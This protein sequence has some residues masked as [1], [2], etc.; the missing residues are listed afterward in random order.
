MTMT[1]Y[2]DDPAILALYARLGD[3]EAISERGE[4]GATPF[5]SPREAIYAKSYLHPKIIEG[6]AC[7][8]GGYAAAERVRAVLLPS[9]TQGMVTCREGESPAVALAEAGFDELALETE[10]LVTALLVSGSG[11]R[12]LTHRDY[13]GSV[14]GLGLERDVVGDILVIDPHSAYLICKG[15]IVPFLLESLT[16]VGNDPVKVKVLPPRTPLAVEKKTQP[17]RD[18]VASPRLDCVVAALCNLSR[19]KAQNVIKSGLAEVNY[20]VAESCDLHL[21][22]PCVLSVRGVG[23]FSV[24][25]FDGETRKGRL[26]LVAEKYV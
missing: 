14:L 4:V 3:L 10:E 7:L 23:K 16:H 22:A 5:L 20:E 24:L 9:Y 8:W 19:E 17:I 18:T 6:S 1:K 25:A 11:Y 26:R 2:S 21:T 13:L 12:D 15:E